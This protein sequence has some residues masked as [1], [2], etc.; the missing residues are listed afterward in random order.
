MKKLIHG[1]MMV[2]LLTVGCTKPSEAIVRT[3]AIKEGE[4]FQNADE[5]SD[6]RL[7]Y[8]VESIGER[9]ITV[10]GCVWGDCQLIVDNPV[11]LTAR[12]EKTACKM[13][14]EKPSDYYSVENKFKRWFQEMKFW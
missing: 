4:C 10:K 13:V 7:T 6:N 9:G 1:S 11:P 2:V 8:Y 5:P 12:V 14:G 3:L